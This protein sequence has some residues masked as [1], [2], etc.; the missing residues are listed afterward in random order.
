MTITSWC[1][2]TR[3]R[4]LS[5]LSSTDISDDDANLFITQAHTQV[6]RQGFVKIRDEQVSKDDNDRYFV[7]G[8]Y[9]A[10]SDIDGSVDTGDITLYEYNPTTKLLTD[11]SVGVDNIDGLNNYFTLATGYPTD[12]DYQVYVTYWISRQPITELVG[13]G[14][15][16]ESAVSDWA[17][18]LSFKRIKTL[19][20]K[21]G[22]ISWNSGGQNINRSEKD[23]DD[24][25]EVHKKRYNVL[26]NRVKPFYG[27][28][29]R[30]GRGAVRRFRG[31]ERYNEPLT[32]NGKLNFN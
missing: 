2:L 11:I 3:F 9:F 28:K 22:I 15:I 23:F 4:T 10:D 1:T 25:V 29:V 6:K 30:V 26:I 13:E 8:K 16:L 7:E 21:R 32:T 24:M 31:P 20:L 5:G 14:S 18:I 17:T 19:R 12:D 27:R